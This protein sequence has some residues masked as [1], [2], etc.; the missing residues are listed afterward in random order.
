MIQSSEIDHSAVTIHGQY[1]AHISWHGK[2]GAGKRVEAL[3]RSLVTVPAS[4]RVLP[5]QY[6]VAPKRKSMWQEFQDRYLRGQVPI[7]PDDASP[8]QFSS[9]YSFVKTIAAIKE[10]VYGCWEL[11]M[12][13]SR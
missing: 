6:V 2:P 4:F 12:L 5:F 8:P 11:Y 10:I 7:A 1:P 3:E 13:S 9:S